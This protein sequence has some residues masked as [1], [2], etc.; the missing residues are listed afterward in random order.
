M[1]QSWH[2]IKLFTSQ[3]DRERER[4]REIEREKQ[5]ERACGYRGISVLNVL[6]S[7]GTSAASWQIFSKHATNAT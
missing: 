4:E 7:H 3:K 2:K 5:F 6:S 1:Q